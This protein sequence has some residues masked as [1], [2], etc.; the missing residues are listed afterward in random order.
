VCCLFWLVGAK[1]L[2]ADDEVAARCVQATFDSN[3]LAI[4][5]HFAG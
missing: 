3:C 4:A 5:K 1:V 2:A